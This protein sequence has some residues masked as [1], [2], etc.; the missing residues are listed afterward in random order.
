VVV[1]PS[2]VPSSPTAPATATP[3]LVGSGGVEAARRRGVL[4]K[5][6]KS[7]SCCSEVGS[8]EFKGCE[9]GRFCGGLRDCRPTLPFPDDDELREWDRDEEDPDVG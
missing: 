6:V 7:D 1:D 5:G 4:G 8:E 3:A 2:S 9:G